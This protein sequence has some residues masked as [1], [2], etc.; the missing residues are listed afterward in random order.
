MDR[1][2]RYGKLTAIGILA[3]IGLALVMNMTGCSTV[4]GLARDVGAMSQA[5][6]E[7]MNK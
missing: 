7:A 2:K 1:V 5:T 6:R 3:G 4:E